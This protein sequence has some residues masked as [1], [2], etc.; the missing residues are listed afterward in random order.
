MEM[1]FH[2]LLLIDFLFGVV[3]STR[4][5][6]FVLMKLCPQCA[7]NKTIDVHEGW[8]GYYTG[9]DHLQTYS[10]VQRDY[11]CCKQ[12][13]ATGKSHKLSTD[14]MLAVIHIHVVIC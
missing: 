13:Y 10:N 4:F 14:V 9:R 7:H 12:Q 1:L 3:N 2:I 8:L 11:T 6:P 5:V